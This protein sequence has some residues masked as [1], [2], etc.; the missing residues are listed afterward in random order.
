LIFGVTNVGLRLWTMFRYNCGTYERNAAT[1][2]RQYSAMRDSELRGLK[3]LT[4]TNKRCEV[5]ASDIGTVLAKFVLFV[6]G[7]V[8]QL[9]NVDEQ[10]AYSFNL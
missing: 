1:Y 6:P 5:L 10:N 7:T 4:K 9:Y 2:F 8:I 3:H